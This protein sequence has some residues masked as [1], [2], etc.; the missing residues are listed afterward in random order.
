MILLH[1]LS[2]KKAGTTITVSKF[3]FQVG[4]AASS[5]L[6]LDDAGVWE[7]H[8]EIIWPKA[9]ALKV[10]SDSK[11]VTNVNGTKIN[12]TDLHEGDLIEAGAVKM[13]FGF[14]PVRQK[15]LVPRELLTWI[16]LAA[17]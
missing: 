12:E 16:G 17:L 6:A 8:F 7:R 11:A 10:Q 2:G 14:S 1:I 5:G 15:S 4:R 9:D 3:P 13:R